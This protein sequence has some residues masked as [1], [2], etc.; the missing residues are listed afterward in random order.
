LLSPIAGKKNGLFLQE[1]D[2]RIFP[3]IHD[4]GAEENAEIA[5]SKEFMEKAFFFSQFL[6]ATGFPHS[7]LL[8]WM[9]TKAELSI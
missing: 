1:M 5:E 4:L 6:V 9:P 8:P 2:Y 3:S 7:I